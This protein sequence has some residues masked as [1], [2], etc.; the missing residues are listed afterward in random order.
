METTLHNIEFQL[1]NVVENAPFPIG[2]YTGREMK[3]VLANKAMIK[4][5]GKGND[6]IGKSYFDILPEL[7]G[8]G[9]YDKLWQVLDTGEPYE[10]KNSRVD[11]IIDG[12]LTTHYFN[13]AFTPLR[14]SSGTVYGVMN[15]GADVTDLNVAKQQTMEAEEKLRLAV[16]SAELGTYEINLFTDAVTISGHFR[17]IWDIDDA[18]ITKEI[19]VSRLHPEDLHIREI[20]FKNMGPDGKVAYDIRIIHKDKTMHWLRING[21]IIKNNTGEPVSMVGIAQDI[22]LQKESEEQLSGL[23]RQRTAELQ[24]SNDDLLQFSHIVSHD[25]KEPLRKIIMF[26]K[27]LTDIPEKKTQHVY[28]D[29][30]IAA[31]ERMGTLIDGILTYSSTNSAGFPVESVDLNAIMIG[32]KKDLEL[33]IEEKKAIFVEQSLPTVEGSA[34]LLQ[35]LFYNLVSN[36]LKFSKANVPPRVI[37]SSVPISNKNKSF[38]RI[39]IED[40]GIGIEPQHAERIFDA[41]ERLHSKDQY[42]GTGLGLSMCRKIIERHYGSIELLSE[43]DGS[44]FAVE[45][46]IK[47]E[48]EFL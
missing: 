4:T 17:Q 30:I 33:L 48:S 42:E 43:V 41:F 14:D 28:L 8:H 34:V 16:N 15:T 6:I 12:I 7:K 22:T 27:L 44:K 31:G 46:P 19:I 36:A 37:V 26:S 35:R 39:I 25:L 5:M 32:I 23:V 2:V 38:I 47:Q 40:N 3:V 45:L 9:I 13:Y 18:V 11:L 10:I 20:A 29:R 1:K 21:T 24:R